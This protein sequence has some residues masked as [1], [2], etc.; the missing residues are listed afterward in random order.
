MLLDKTF[1]TTLRNYSTLFLV[2]AFV[3][4]PLH[5]AYSLLFRDILAL[6]E[7]HA[8]IEQLPP[9]QPV[10]GIT[11]D[12]LERARL[13][14]LALCGL[15]VLFIP[16]LWRAT[17]RVVALDRAGRLPTATEAWRLR[18]VPRGDQEAEGRPAVTV[19]AAL[20][21]SFVVWLL[22]ERIGGMVIE[23]VP[24]RLLFLGLGLVRAVSLALAA[25][26][27]LVAAVLAAR[28]RHRERSAP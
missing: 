9:A 10:G 5:L 17:D 27:A 4:V 28:R 24:D 1:A 26:F 20:S 23:L 3:T 6:S 15:E 8:A 22:A 12:D 19:A 2:V 7:I 13:A 21:F 16:L 18:D 14:Y 11:A 25:P